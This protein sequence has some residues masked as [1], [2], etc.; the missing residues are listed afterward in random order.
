VLILDLDLDLDLNL[1]LMKYDT[2]IIGAG[3]GGLTAGAKLAKEG[4]KVLLIEQHDRPGGCATTFQRGDFTFEV[5][6]HEMDGLDP[7]DIKTRIFKDLGVFDQVDFLKVPEFYHFVQGD[8]QLTIPHDPAEASEI[9]IHTFPD[10]VEG[11]KAYF[12]QLINAR[13][14]AKESENQPERSLGDFLDS[15]ISND[16]LKMVLLGNL[17]Y[18]HDDPYSLSLNYYSTAQ[19]SY[20]QGGGNFI[21]GGSQKLSDCLAGIIV[22]NGGEVLLNHLVTSIITDDTKATGVTYRKMGKGDQTLM[23]AQ[24]DEIIANASIPMV[25]KKLL[26]GNLGNELYKQVEELEN[27]ASLLTIYLGFDTPPK[28]LGSTKY[29]TFLFDESMRSQKDIKANNRGDFAR[30]SFTFIDYSQVDSALTTDDKGVGVICCV[31]YLD[32]WE[33]LDQEQYKAKKREVAAIFLEKLDRYIPGIKSHVT[34]AEVGTSK[35]VARYTLNPDG[36]V[37]GFAQTPY[38]VRKENVQTLDHLHFASA[39]TKTGGGFSGAIFSGYLCA[40]GVLRKSG[41]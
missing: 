24:A 9:L 29:S 10:E 19:G 3:L 22:A 27:G 6:L 7:R 30:R 35:T 20:Y 25:A 40:M 26:P 34:H 32:E 37:Y 16:L 18:F 15:I 28:Q 11:I 38:R 41:S 5:G 23:S 36:A 31:D 2:I 13:K 33:H 14:R 8:F 4:K 17:G 12:D 39:W 1:N 21:R